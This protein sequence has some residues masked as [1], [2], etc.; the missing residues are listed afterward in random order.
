MARV[1]KSNL[2]FDAITLEGSL[3]TSAKF[4][5]VAERKNRKPDE[6]EDTDYGIPKGLTL[7]DETARYFR[8]GQ[9]LFRELH[10]SSAPSRHKTIEFTEQLL[11]TV[12]G[13][14]DVQ[15]VHGP[16]VL[17]GRNFFV[18]LEAHAGRVPVIV[19]PPS[20]DLDHASNSL[21]HDR[22]RSAASALQDWL[23]ADENS[24]W[25][26]CTNGESLRLLRDNESLT[27]P[28]YLEADLR[29]IFEADDYAGFS[30]LW[31]VLHA[32]RFGRARALPADCPLERWRES[33]SK[34]GLAARDRLRDGVE[35]ALLALGTG[36]L[37]SPA[38]G[39]LSSRL[40]EGAWPIDEYFRQLLRLVYRLIFLLAAEDRNLL[41]L[42][43]ASQAQRKLYAQGYS[44]GAL[45]DRA[46]RRSGWDSFH[47]RWSGL[48]VTFLALAN[49]EHR[50]GL[51]ALGGIFATTATPEL[52]K[53]LIS[54]RYLMEAIFR[55]AWL[56]VDGLLM[57]VNWRDMETEELGSV[58]ESLLEL[59]PRL[60]IDGREF[61]FAEGAQTKG[62]ARKTSGSYYTPDS[63]VQV[64]LDSALDPVL[65][66]IESESEDPVRGLLSATV[67]DPACGSGHFLLSAA[68]RIAKRV[69]RVRHGDI[70]TEQQR[71]A[72]LRDVVRSCIHGVDRNPMAV[73]LTKVALWIETVEP[74]KPLGFLDTNI[75]LGDSLFGIF[76]LDALRKGIPD[77]AYKALTGDDKTVAKDF[78][79]KNRDEIKGQGRMALTGPVVEPAVLP[80]L[81]QSLR[82]VRQLPEDTAAEIEAK[83]RRFD[84]A[85]QDPSLQR[86]AEAADLY[87]AAFLTPKTVETARDQSNSLIPTTGDV[88]IK[89]RGDT[90]Y[91]ELLGLSRQL[92][93]EARAFHWPM[94]FPDIMNTGG[95]DVVI[96]NPPWE[97]VKLQEQEFFASR[98][99]AIAEAP[100]AAA[101]AK[102]IKELKI[103]PEGSRERG[104]F[105]AFEL[106]KRITEASSQFAR[107]GAR[108]SGRYPLAGIGDVNTYALFSELFISLR[109]PSGTAGIIVPTGI[110]LDKTTQPI[111]NYLVSSQLL[112]SIKSFYEVRQWFVATDDRKPFCILTIGHNAQNPSFSFGIR[113]ISE[114]ENPE[115]SFDLSATEIAAIN[116]NT[117][118]APVFRSRSDASLT[119]NI[120]RQVPVLIN[121]ADTSYGN[122]WGIGFM[123]M[124][125]M[126]ND[127]GSFRTASQ[128]REA[129]YEPDGPDWIIAEDKI[130]STNDGGFEAPA[131]SRYVPLYEAKMIHIFDSRWATF[132]ADDARDSGQ[133][134]K[135]SP[136]FHSTPRYWVSE[137]AVI[138]RMVDKRWRY[139][140][141]FGW[142]DVVNPN[143][144]RTMISAAFPLAGVGHKLPLLISDQSPD[145]F[146][147]LIANLASLVLD[148]VARQKIGGSSLT[149]FY[150]KQLTVLP[151]DFY[152]VSDVNFVRN[153]VVELTYTNYSMRPF[154]RD[155]G[156]EGEPYVWD[157][158]R[159]ATLRA[160]LD[161]FYARAYGLSR[162]ELRYILDPADLMGADYPSE[163]FRVLKEKE[164]KLYKE[165]RTQRLVL[166]AWDRMER[167]ELHCPAPYDKRMA[168][169]MA[170]QAMLL[171][172]RNRPTQNPLL[173]AGPLFEG[174][175]S[176][177]I[178]HLRFADPSDLVNDVWAMPS[179]NSIS[180]QLQIAAILKQVSGPTAAAQVRLAV[181]YA[182]NPQ[183]LTSRLSGA[184]LKTWQRLVG[185]SARI[186]GAANVIQFIPWVNTEW[187]D[188]YTQ[189]RGMH[190][191]LEDAANDTWAPGSVV[192]DFMTEGWADGRAAFVI[193]AM[194]GMEI[195]TSIAELP[196]DLQAWVRA[197]AA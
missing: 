5:A 104:L 4:A 84:S 108:D 119:A 32:S 1:R 65:D 87:I 135:A 103:A 74:G 79:Q 184:D 56:R 96:G 95:F 48:R 47:D 99:L 39:N 112:I 191:L 183:L 181:L 146:C 6:Q 113:A 187:R 114:L 180:V 61:T 122:P 197:H 71:L 22:R 140:W 33:G 143:V 154:A 116:P 23:N 13:F 101:R 195:E 157:E 109:K 170:A 185:N 58:Y 51:P 64:L 85:I 14:S 11:R 2:S 57:P 100:N 158:D 178:E 188:A 80:K 92:A 67:I 144:L 151:P 164:L 118:T 3:L 18:T 78:A 162:D 165:Y 77:A 15:V 10:A 40:R 17:D 156:Y 16:K 190:A 123:T 26:F 97:R 193:K 20:D 163:T 12:L 177:P 150:L 153:R 52:D 147:G 50:L 91:G 149:Y 105:I 68:R 38:N 176:T 166:D 131:P 172:Q 73:E 120:Y 35:A 75:R 161:A 24:L 121:E 28:A 115:R 196:V 130:R 31:L 66:R 136:A 132:D 186:S 102:L 127:S 148:Y 46:I 7:R 110:A 137:K 60:S 90:V 128:L 59:T 125:H 55:L 76:N 182:L 25:G 42:P 43:N 107:I 70:H 27:R 171:V 159:R 82:A 89:M 141:L 37:I 139:R 9:A 152:A 111:F 81:A 34:E 189:L 30:A 133:T 142:R 167:G 173:G 134:E 63:L 86:F 175:E 49:G 54:N 124:F 155:L 160:E 62:N 19:V 126:A 8:M 21:S 129:G 169:A 138:D 44:L 168:P 145:L 83:R 88:Q 117:R 94:E 192:Q 93:S 194:E 72:A 45:R 174:I 69:V 179:Y 98:E 106:A 36:F 41:H 29:Q 53:A